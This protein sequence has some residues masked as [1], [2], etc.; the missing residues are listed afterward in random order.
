MRTNTGDSVVAPNSGAV[1]GIWNMRKSLWVIPVLLSLSF[2]AGPVWAQCGSLGA[3]STT[4]SDGNGTWSGSGN[5]TS[6]APNTSTNAC[7]LDGASTVT[8]DPNGNAL[9]LQLS[10]GNV[11]NINI[12]AGLGLGSGPS[13]NYGAINNY[14]SIGNA[15]PFFNNG[16]FTNSG[17]IE[18][19]CT[20]SVLTNNGTFTNAT[21]G[22]ISV[23]WELVNNGTFY[24]EAGATIF[25]A[26]AAAGDGS[27]ENY[28]TLIN[29]GTL[30]TDIVNYIDNYGELTNSVAGVIINN[31][32]LVN[33]SL[34]VNLGTINNDGGVL[35][36]N[37]VLINEGAI[38]NTFCGACFTGQFNNSGVLTNSGLISNA[39]GATLNNAGAF[40]NSGVLINAGAI[41][42]AGSFTNFGTVTVTNSGIFTTS[43]NY[44]Q[45]A[46]STLVNGTLSATGSAIVDIQGGTL[47]G[48]G[49]INGNVRVGGGYAGGGYVAFGGTI[50]P[51]APGTPGTF[52]ILGNYEQTGTGTL[53]ELIGPLSHSLL[54]VSG[55]VTLD[56]GAFLDITLLNGYD[57]LGQTFDIMDYNALTGQFSNGSGF[58]DDGYLWDVS[59][60]QN[61]I[62]VTAVQAPEPDSQLLLFV[63]LAALAIYSHRK[64][65]KTQR[66]A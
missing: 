51:G 38:Y 39:S 65:D 66:T 5:W 21:N 19:C 11:L 33:G 8:L 37:G 58:W 57:P 31:F 29:A 34:L 48:T 14:G 9:G 59:Y 23:N 36:S 16:A 13:Y 20:R 62:D 30:V 56:S 50:T 63:G 7:I 52:T 53:E 49:T 24:N 3:P 1:W 46:G 6:G 61:Q 47:G 32:A 64:M 2:G 26:A 54:N 27:L 40:T 35:A 17:F 60:G 41:N 12:A 15:G 18:I 10:S 25:N 45:T 22:Y 44:M 28:G 4:W 43:T 42:S 55:D